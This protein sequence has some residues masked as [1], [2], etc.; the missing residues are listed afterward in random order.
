[1]ERNMRKNCL[2]A[3]LVLLLGG[4]VVEGP[5]LPFTL[6]KT[7]KLAQG[8]F[9]LRVL[10][11]V[12]TSAY[13]PLNAGDYRLKDS[14]APFFDYVVLGAAELRQDEYGVRL[15][16]PDSLRYVL[17]NRS[18]FIMPLQRK[19]IRVLL[20]LTGG[21]AGVSFG[22][23]TKDDILYFNRQIKDVLDHYG[24]NGVEFY[25][26]GAASSAGTG[27]FPWP[28]GE[29]GGVPVDLFPGDA[30]AKTARWNR[31]GDTMNNAIF[32]LRQMLPDYHNQL[33]IVREENYG[34]YLPFNVS[35]A[36]FTARDD[37][38]NYFV[39]ARFDRFGSDGQGESV[40]ASVDDF[41]FAPLAVDLGGK[42]GGVTPPL[43]GTGGQDIAGFSARLLETAGGRTVCK[44]GL[45][46]YHNL[47]PRSTELTN[48]AVYLSVTANTVFGEE[49]VC[50]D[51]DRLKTW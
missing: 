20:A 13:N 47:R 11:Y 21:G 22:T 49:V 27:G 28:E 24:L 45:L 32:R 46:Y 1:M 9:S 29:F 8:N 2:L 30:A 7:D 4:C 35:D 26:S 15:Y 16:L 34:R 6:P 5:D 40:N 37:Q 39:N 43:S 12:D 31:G 41:K 48:Q 42:N 25:D 23:F 19:G 51:G 38:V 3:A 33:I 10:C 50:D 17:E 18:R 14:G 44:Y 36:N